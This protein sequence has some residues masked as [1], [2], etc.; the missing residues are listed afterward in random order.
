MLDPS[1]TIGDIL[2]STKVCRRAYTRV[3]K[4]MPKITDTKVICSASGQ[5][6]EIVEFTIAPGTRPVRLCE[7]RSSSKLIANASFRKTAFGADIFNVGE[8]SDHVV[9][10]VNLSP[11][12]SP[13]TIQV[14]VKKQDREPFEL[15]VITD[16]MFFPSIRVPIHVEQLNEAWDTAV[17]EA[18][19]TKKDLESAIDVFLLKAP[20]L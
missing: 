12:D 6:I 8:Y 17:E 13:K 16:K 4:V 2:A 10:D 9:L 11:E 18:I 3:Q 1:F 14:A 20:S 5:M 7:V 19:Q 15:S